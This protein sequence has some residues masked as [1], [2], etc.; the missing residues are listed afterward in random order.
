M[1]RLYKVSKEYADGRTALDEV[2]LNV[3]AGEF[4][5]LTGPTGSGKS[6]LLR[7]LFG[8]ETPSGGRGVVNGRNLDRLD[9]PTLA[10]LRREL[11]LVFQDP[12]LID[13]LPI[14]ENVS[15]AAEVAGV[16]RQ[17]ARRTAHDL[18]EMFGL[19]R[20]ADASPSVLSA[21]ERQ[22]VGLA[23]ALINRPVLLLADEPTGNLDPDASAEI[24]ELLK[25]VHGEGTTVLIATHDQDALAML[26]CRT[27]FM[28][29]GRVHEAGEYRM[30]S[31]L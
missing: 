18:L 17:S 11:G 31:S 12:R 1:I 9:R 23:R 4:V 27:L 2:T 16:G 15:L 10:A 6:T 8:S 14:V 3:E 19:D 20:F 7:I 26:D 24:I 28:Y 30:S 25:E 22:R 5:L 21:G 13:R 29:Q